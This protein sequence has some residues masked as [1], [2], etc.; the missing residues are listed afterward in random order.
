MKRA[1]LFLSFALLCAG[2]A[3]PAQVVSSGCHPSTDLPSVKVIKKV[4]EADT[5]IEDL[6]KLF[7][8]ERKDHGQ[9]VRDYNSLYKECVTDA[10]TDR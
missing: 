7:A 5:S 10:L 2:C 3:S 9:D 1:L 8:Q 4:P 6:F